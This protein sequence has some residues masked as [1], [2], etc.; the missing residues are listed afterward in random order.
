MARFRRWVAGA[1]LVPALAAGSAS[2]SFFSNEVPVPEI[3]L[4]AAERECLAVAA[5]LTD[6]QHT[7]LARGMDIW[8]PRENLDYL[9]S[10]AATIDARGGARAFLASTK[11]DVGAR[12]I[13]G[14]ALSVL[15]NP[16]VHTPGSLG[17]AAE[18]FA[19]PGP[20]A[21]VDPAC[22]DPSPEDFAAHEAASAELDKNPDYEGRAR[23]EAEA[24]ARE[25]S[26]AAE[27]SE[28]ERSGAERPGAER[29]AAPGGDREEAERA[30]AREAPQSG[31]PEPAISATSTTN[32]EAT[33]QASET[34]EAESTAASADD[35]DAP[36]PI[37]V[38]RFI[39]LRG[40]A[41]ETGG[42]GALPPELRTALTSSPVAWNARIFGLGG[43]V[44]LRTFSE[45][46][47]VSA[48]IDAADDEV[49][50]GSDIDRAVI[51]RAGEIA[52][53]V[54]GQGGGDMSVPGDRNRV[55]DAEI[56]RLLST[57]LSAAAPDLTAV[58][59]ALVADREDGPQRLGEIPGGSYVAPGISD[60]EPEDARYGKLPY[61]PTHTIG[62][63]LAF[64]WPD[65]IGV[66]NG[67]EKLF[68]NLGASDVIFGGPSQPA[69]ATQL[70]GEATGELA[71]IVA[72]A[73]ESLSEIDEYGHRPMGTLN[74]DV[75]TSVASAVGPRLYELVGGDGGPAG[76][77]GVGPLD[78]LNQAT[79]LIAVLA[80]SPEATKV[81]ATHSADAISLAEEQFAAEPG[82]RPIQIHSR[83]ETA[84]D[85]GVRDGWAVIDARGSNDARD[86]VETMLANGI[87]YD[88]A[89]SVLTKAPRGEERRAAALLDSD[90][91]VVADG[92]HSRQVR[93]GDKSVADVLDQL[94]LTIN[95]EPGSPRALYA[96]LVGAPSDRD[97]FAREK[98]KDENVDFI[99]RDGSFDR[100]AVAADEELFV[101]L[102]ERIVGETDEAYG[103]A[104]SDAD[105]EGDWLTR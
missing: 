103:K 87:Y 58:H 42:I 92:E 84:M 33:E 56:G 68:G 14:N 49:R 5:T 62:H 99:D 60:N 85:Q 57:M 61:E 35:E 34:P 44:T 39:D 30:D 9:A 46:E 89:A 97:V 86:E 95:A 69:E 18:E 11:N 2:C 3:P 17:P 22:F 7:A 10:M 63:L 78:S 73:R 102:A 48:V 74:P 67:A 81:L 55:N 75:T 16:Q 36:A 93:D 100:R 53:A 37:V 27:E 50:R 12:T 71:R 31:A 79:D 1:L 88:P 96:F 47:S 4:T 66:R 8:I 83:I 77:S 45:L 21:A 104:F 26:A 94:D 23:S 64:D 101:E 54:V 51:A 65:A 40:E 82:D 15:A 41:P 20:D 105:P 6:D 70:A 59:D 29:P 25:T 80:T 76:L 32:E 90:P 72:G 52:G 19:G 91:I 38:E 24:F 98:W 43:R 28:A 13:L